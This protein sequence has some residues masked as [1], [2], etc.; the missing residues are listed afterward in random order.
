MEKC[1]AKRGLATVELLYRIPSGCAAFV[2]HVLTV[3]RTIFPSLLER[4]ESR[5][6]NPAR[7]CHGFAALRRHRKLAAHAGR[8]REESTD[9][10]AGS[11]LYRC[12]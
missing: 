7:H 12:S 8:G 6:R 2:A 5:R 10:T 9:N 4:E 1:D 11:S 3:S